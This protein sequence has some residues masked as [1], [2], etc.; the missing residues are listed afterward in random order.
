MLETLKKGIKH[1][2]N[3]GFD[4]ETYGNNNKFYLCS[5]FFSEDKKVTFYEKED[6][7]TFILKNE[8]LFN[9]SRV[10]AHNLGF[11]FIGMFWDTGNFEK[12]RII[13]RSADF[14]AAKSYIYDNS[15]NFLSNSKNH[16]QTTLT[17]L[18]TMSFFKGSLEKIGDFIGCPKMTKPDF[19]GQKPKNE[20]ERKYL[21]IYNI[22]DSRITKL[23]ADFLQ[24]TYNGV[25][26]ELKYTIASTAKDLFKRKYLGDKKYYIPDAH[27]LEHM[28]KCLY[29]GRTEVLNRGRTSERLNVYDFNSLY[30]SVM[31]NN[32][33]P[34]VNTIKKSKIMDRYL[35]NDYEGYCYAELEY[36]DNDKIPFLQ[37]RQ[38]D[39]LLF[40]RGRIRGY[41]TFPEI[42]KAIDI[43][44]KIIK[45]KDGYYFTKSLNFF[46]DFVK[47]QYAIR[48]MYKSQKNPMELPIKI[49]MNSLFGKFGERIEQQELK[50]FN[51][52]TRQEYQRA[53]KIGSSDYYR[54]KT[55][56]KGQQLDFTIPII[57]AY[58]TAYARIKLYNAIQDIQDNVFYM[59]TD[60]IFTTKT[61]PSSSKLGDLKLEYKTK[62]AF[63]I[64]PKF[65]AV[66][67]DDD[68]TKIKIKGAY[69]QNQQI[70]DFLDIIKSRKTSSIKFLKLRQAL[71]SG[72]EPNSKTDM[73][74]E[75]SL[76]DNKRDWLGQK[77]NLK[78]FQESRP[79]TVT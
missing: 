58:V 61:M 36:R 64:K 18:D 67:T 71:I 70:N 11:D 47:D 15:F 66:I 43:G 16:H 69:I 25:G 42:R 23:F 34:D 3:I 9:N 76:E 27:I 2:K 74:K 55:K 20:Q 49:I 46:G 35:I 51:E 33:Y 75:F 62:E 48:M 72:L 38:P 7:L 4:I 39:K 28:Y 63:L 73:I 29:G 26:A 78:E 59:D 40:P 13:Q 14:I 22:N 31:D 5:L 52:L 37:Q 32:L 1:Y 19:I 77:L 8:Q 60:S 57:S 21:E 24:E 12:F 41:Y 6:F 30:P 65:Y 56:K 50:H 68:K 54:F 10:W 53:D 17:F 79:I 44:Y 45:I